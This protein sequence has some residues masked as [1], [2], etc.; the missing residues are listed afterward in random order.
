MWIW[1]WVRS[2]WKGEDISDEALLE[3]EFVSPP[4]QPCHSLVPTLVTL[5]PLY[6]GGA[7]AMQH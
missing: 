1:M 3:E 2:W 7:D 6:L 4:W 5:C